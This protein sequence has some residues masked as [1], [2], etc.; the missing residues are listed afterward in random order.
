V[1]RILVAERQRIDNLGIRAGGQ[2]RQDGGWR[3]WPPG[4]RA[5][6]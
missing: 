3:S 5:W 4:I 2:H 1:R 6:R